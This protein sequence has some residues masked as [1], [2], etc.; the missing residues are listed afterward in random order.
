[1]SNKL[2][3]LE[4]L[5]NTIAMRSLRSE[6]KKSLEDSEDILKEEIGDTKGFLTLGGERVIGFVQGPSKPKLNAK[7]L[8]AELVETQP[9]LVAKHTHQVEGVKSFQL[10][11]DAEAILMAHEVTV[12]VN[13]LVDLR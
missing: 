7:A 11:P 12:A 1:M 6:V 5:K 9:G 10:E 13:A 4:A 3:D 8:L 2:Q